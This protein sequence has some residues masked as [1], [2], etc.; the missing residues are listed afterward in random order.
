[1]SG[2]WGIIPSL[3]FLLPH[4]GFI[5]FRL[6]GFAYSRPHV[7]FSPPPRL[8]LPASASGGQSFDRQ[9]RSAGTDHSEEVSWSR[10][11]ADCRSL[12]RLTQLILYRYCHLHRLS[13]PPALSM[14]FSADSPQIIATLA[15][16]PTVRKTWLDGNLFAPW[17][18][19]AIF[20]ATQGETRQPFDPFL[21]LCSNQLSRQPLFI[22]L[23]RLGCRPCLW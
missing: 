18:A 14:A 3:N 22:R 8:Y 21:N 4:P 11:W 6:P 23:Q 12:S 10:F 17:K 9:R 16:L 1:M 19:Y 20:S 5:H 7:S 2:K 15:Y 13:L